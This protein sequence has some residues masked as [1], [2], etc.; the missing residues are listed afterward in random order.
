MCGKL[1]F[2]TSEK[3]PP[4]ELIDTTGAGD[5]FVGAILY[6]NFATSS[7]YICNMQVGSKIELH[8][9]VHYNSIVSIPSL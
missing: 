2:G 1:Y 4:S 3:I 6:G 7:Y 8:Y 9:I 5:A